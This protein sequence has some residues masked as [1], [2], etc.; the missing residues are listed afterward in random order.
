MHSLYHSCR[1]TTAHG[2]LSNDLETA[3]VVTK[4]TSTLDVFPCK[5]KFIFVEVM[6]FPWQF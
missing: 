5:A 6:L 2:L 3:S 4:S 1:I